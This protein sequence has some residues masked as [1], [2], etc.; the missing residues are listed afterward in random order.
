MVLVRAAVAVLLM[1]ALP[2]LAMA[3]K[4]VALVVGNSAYQHTPKIDNLTEQK[5]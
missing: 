4:R 1:I 2:T 3:D 5:S